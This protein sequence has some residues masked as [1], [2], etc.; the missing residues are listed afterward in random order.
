MQGIHYDAEHALLDNMDDA[1]LM[2]LAGNA[3]HTWCCGASLIS[4]LFVLS[5]IWARRHSSAAASA[6]AAEASPPEIPRVGKKRSLDD[7]C[8]IWGV[9]R[10][11]AAI[12]QQLQQS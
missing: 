7:L 3:F 11:R 5:E 2:S 12:A 8:E 10:S 6:E 1:R 4:L 9:S